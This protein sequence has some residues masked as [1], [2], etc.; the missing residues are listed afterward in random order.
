VDG[1]GIGCSAHPDHVHFR[2]IRRAHRKFTA[3][4]PHHARRCI[5]RGPQ[6]IQH[7]WSER[8]ARASRCFGPGVHRGGQR[9][10]NDSAKNGGGQQAEPQEI[11]LPKRRRIAPTDPIHSGLSVMVFHFQ[12]DRNASSVSLCIQRPK[13]CSFGCWPN[14][15]VRLKNSLRLFRLALASNC[16]K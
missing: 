12:F 9:A 15:P 14:K 16:Q 2:R 8:S 6:G 7:S 1:P 5:A 3:G 11:N 10:K 4:N 13:G